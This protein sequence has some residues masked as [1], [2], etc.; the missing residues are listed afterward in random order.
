[1]NLGAI[2]RNIV[3]N[4]LGG[5]WIVFLSLAVI[6]VQIGILGIEAFGVIGVLAALQTVFPLLDLGMCT[7]LMQRTATDTAHGHQTARQLTA[8][9]TAVFLSTATAAGLALAWKADWLARH[10]LQISTLPFDTVVGAIQL[11]VIAVVIRCPVTVCSALIAGMNRL[12]VLNLLRSGVHTLRVLGGLLVLIF[13]RELLPLLQ[14]EIAVTVL[15]C[16]AYLLACRRLLPGLSLWPRYPADVMRGKWRFALGVNAV[17]AIGMLLTQTDKFAISAALPLEALGIYHLAYGAT[18]WI[19]LIQGGFNSAIL[20]SFAADFAS[21]RSELLRARNAKVT[22][23]TVYAVTLPAAAILF[24]GSQILGVW[25][26]HSAASAA[27]TVAALLSAGFLLNA[28]VSNCLTLAVASGN[29][30]IPLRVN[31]LGLAIYLPALALLL[32]L[33]GI[34]GAALAWVILNAYYLAVLVPIVQRRLL[35]QG[36]VAWL[37]E[38]FLPFVLLGGALFGGASAMNNIFAGR[39]EWLT[40]C[41]VVIAAGGYVLGGYFLLARELR[42]QITASALSLLRAARPV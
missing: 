33:R 9:A 1:M 39:P 24:F 28:A 14:W 13:Y 35:H 26:G 19:T 15:E 41:I 17:A 32:D 27:A 10:W 34:T 4:G 18:A 36:Y 11:I 38:N 23:L 2:G 22:Q 21:G 40:W 20:P 25:V 30:G 29:P 37:R 42:A 3:S 31:L 5:V 16:A 8:G 6:P 7:T 12:D